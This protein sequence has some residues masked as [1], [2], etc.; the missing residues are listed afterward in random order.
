MRSTFENTNGGYIKDHNKFPKR[1][2][3]TR[4]ML[5]ISHM[6][7]TLPVTNE[8]YVEVHTQGLNNH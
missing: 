8:K 3:C 4:S 6:L 1:I 5:G 7:S 2:T